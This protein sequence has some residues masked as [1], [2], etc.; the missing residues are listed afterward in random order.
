MSLKLTQTNY[1]RWKTQI[2]GLIESQELQNF[3][4]EK[5]Y[6]PPMMVPTS[7]A[8]PTLVDSLDF[9]TWSLDRLLRGWITSTLSEDTLSLVIG[10]HSSLEVWNA[11][12][13]AFA[14]N[15]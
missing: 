15:S 8:T 9:T 10:L 7:D 6:P 5:I 2:L 12:R 11:L 1:L 3:I 13:T 14:H 4:D